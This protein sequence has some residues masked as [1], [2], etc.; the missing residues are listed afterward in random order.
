M[1]ETDKQE[2]VT[3]RLLSTHVLA[4]ELQNMINGGYEITSVISLSPLTSP[5]NDGVFVGSWMIIYRSQL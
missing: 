1:P 5:E 4:R 3:L 2:V